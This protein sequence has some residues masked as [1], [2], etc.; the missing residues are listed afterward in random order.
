MK[1]IGKWLLRVVTLAL[2]ITLVVTFYPTLSGFLRSI[3][4]RMDYTTAAQQISHEMRE[5]GKLTTLE[6][7]DEGVM[8]NTTDAALLGT[9]QT[10]TV[11]YRYELS[12]GV[13]LTRAVVASDDEGLVIYLPDAELILDRLTV[14]GE[15][16]IDDF[17]NLMTEQ[18][19]QAML[20][21]HALS[22]RE[23][24]LGDQAVLMNAWNG[25]AK[26]L[27]GLLSVWLDKQGKPAVRY[28]PLI[29]YTPPL[30]AG[31]G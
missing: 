27:D 31:G 16:K 7:S 2:A 28:L 21:A 30:S 29:E 22:C 8:T 18:R 6:F 15:A 26:A 5:V 23:A 9:V 17:W 19:Y 11:P 12:L 4:S 25:A 13:D 1:R 3:F 14:T 24:Y 20:D 10:V